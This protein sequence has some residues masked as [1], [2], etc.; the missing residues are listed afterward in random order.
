MFP[1]FVLV[2]TFYRK[3]N[4]Y[5]SISLYSLLRDTKQHLINVDLLHE[6]HTHLVL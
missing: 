4:E 2:D 6:K 1:A 3:K 5:F